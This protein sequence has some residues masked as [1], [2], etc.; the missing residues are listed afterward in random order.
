M[1]L[2]M[3]GL[4]R[5]GANM[6]LRLLRGG[7]AVVAYDR[8]SETVSSLGK[9]G[10]DAVFTLEELVQKLIPPRHVWLMV[11]AGSPV[12]ETIGALIPLLESG[13]AIIDGGNSNYRDSIRRAEELSEKGL[14]F[15]DCGTSG[16]N[17]GLEKRFF[18][19]LRREKEGLRRPDP[20]FCS[21][22]RPYWHAHSG[23]AG[24]G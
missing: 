14:H 20:R 7:H 1:Q 13:D 6:T 21:P 8:S 17:L 4:G 15:I 9:Q 23:P 5:M 16:G 11:P 12:T 19:I 22:A 18:P 3:V 10:T 2:G 24:A